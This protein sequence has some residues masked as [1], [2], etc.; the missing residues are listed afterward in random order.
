MR[1]I[2]LAVVVVLSLVLAPIAGE[3]QKAGQAPRVGYIS[4]GSSSDPFR[5]SRFEAFRQGLRELGYVEG[6]NVVLVPRWAEGQPA[7]YP[8]SRLTWSV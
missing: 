5:Q 1:L 4:P 2:G 8:S 3:A 6:R 7:R